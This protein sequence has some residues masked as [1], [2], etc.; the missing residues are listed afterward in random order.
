MQICDLFKDLED[1][2]KKAAAWYKE[3]DASQTSTLHTPC[4]SAKNNLIIKFWL[5]IQFKTYNI[6]L[7]LNLLGNS[8]R[9]SKNIE[10][11]ALNICE[12][13]QYLAI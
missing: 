3:G 10:F 11:L 6:K 8:V 12:I 4:V 2:K 13:T 9:L 1:Q 7:L 5:V